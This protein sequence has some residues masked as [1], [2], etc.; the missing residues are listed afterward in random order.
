MKKQ[1]LIVAGGQIDTDLLKRQ[2]ALLAAGNG[3]LIAADRGLEAL[4]AVEAVPDVAVGDFDSVSAE[5]LAE[6]MAQPSVIFERHRP[7]KDESDTELAFRIAQESGVQELT[8]MGVTGTRLDHVL[9]N[10]HLLKTAL[11]SGLTC[12]ILD[13]NNRIRLTDGPMTF[14][15]SDNEY[16]YLSLIPFTD[17]VT[18]IRLT[19]FKYPLSDYHMVRGTDPGR[20]VSNELADEEAGLEFGE[21]LLLVIESKD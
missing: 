5:V 4:K 11:D 10:I 6:Y 3:L 12:S 14:T 20:C 7:E 13:A 18:H 1:A 16:R 9:A 17:Q 8:L 15:R 21:G 19:G 2:L